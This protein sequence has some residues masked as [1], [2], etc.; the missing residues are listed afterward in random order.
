VQQR[1]INAR[2][3]LM[4]KGQSHAELRSNIQKTKI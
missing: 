1:K 4:N 2:Y 3:N